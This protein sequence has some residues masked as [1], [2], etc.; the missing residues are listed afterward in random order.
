L[1]FFIFLSISLKEVIQIIL[2]PVDII[3]KPTMILLL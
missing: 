2:Y 1:Q 3:Q